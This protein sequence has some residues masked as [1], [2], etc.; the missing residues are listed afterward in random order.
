MSLLRFLCFFIIYFN[1]CGGAAAAAGVSF[2]LHNKCSYTVW[3]GILAGGGHPLLA[4]GGFELQPNAQVSIPAPEG[5]SGRFW[6]RTGCNFDQSG[7]GK[8]CETAD[9][10]GGILQC[11]GTGGAPPASLAEFTLDSPLDFY[12]VSLVDGYNIPISIS[13]T[14][15]NDCTEVKCTFDLNNCPEEL[16]LRLSNSDVDGGSGDGRGQSV[17]G[18]KSACLALNKPEYCC[19]GSF[20]DPNVCKPTDYSKVFKQACPTSYSYPYDDKTSTFTCKGA[21]Y[22]ISFC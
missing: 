16:K 7:R 6:G 9:C 20:N 5:W 18:C 1:C 2:T 14:G 13:P 4:N 10:G 22:I 12:D 21:S 15:S 11:A 17:V 8:I 19:S 3:P